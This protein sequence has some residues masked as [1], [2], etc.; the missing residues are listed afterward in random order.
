MK[1]LVFLMLL[2]SWAYATP[3]QWQTF[4]VYDQD[5]GY[6]SDLDRTE[7]GFGYDTESG[8]AWIE[9]NFKYCCND[10]DQMHDNGDID[11]TIRIPVEGLT[12]NTQD[13]QIYF[14]ANGTQVHC[15]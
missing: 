7:T 8:H 4:H 12:Y 6:E 9:V 2:S 13:K 10:D 15:G 11:D 3:P 14:I 5:V 1:T